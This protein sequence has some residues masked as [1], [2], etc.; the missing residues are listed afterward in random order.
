MCQEPLEEVMA[1]VDFPI[2]GLTEEVFGLRYSRDGSSQAF[3][4]DRGISL[5]YQSDRYFPFLHEK[6]IKT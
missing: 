1:S 3:L 6:I 2:Y 5:K 4:S